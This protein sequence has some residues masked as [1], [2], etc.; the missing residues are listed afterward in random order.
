MSNGYNFD[1]IIG[2]LDRIYVSLLS[3]Y[4]KIC[5][6]YKYLTSMLD[7]E[8]YFRHL[9]EYNTLIKVFEINYKYQISYI[10]DIYKN[11]KKI[12]DEL[13]L[14]SK[15]QAIKKDFDKIKIKETC[16]FKEEDIQEYLILNSEICQPFILN[17]EI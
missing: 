11:N 6:K 12:C 8:K 13:N 15:I 17:F 5:T 10:N 2:V 7:L 4:Y 1:F 9:N 16:F 14:L 3:N